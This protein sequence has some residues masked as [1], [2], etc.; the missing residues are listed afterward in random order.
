MNAIAPVASCSRSIASDGCKT[1]LTQHAVALDENGDCSPILMPEP[2]TIDH[3]PT[4]RPR[5]GNLAAADVPHGPG[6]LRVWP[7][8][9]LASVRQLPCRWLHRGAGWGQASFPGM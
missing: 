5:A 8:A 3:L 1:Q 7:E 9:A 4:L 2:G 6:N